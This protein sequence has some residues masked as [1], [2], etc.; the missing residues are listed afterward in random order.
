VYYIVSELGLMA[1][2][3]LTVSMSQVF[4][5]NHRLLAVLQLQQDF[6]RGE[7]HGMDEAARMRLGRISCA[8]YQKDCPERSN[9][10]I[11]CCAVIA[12]HVLTT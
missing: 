10:F 6:K 12:S 11:L 9:D 7:Y 8:V 1:P 2:D 4:D 3:V 5:G